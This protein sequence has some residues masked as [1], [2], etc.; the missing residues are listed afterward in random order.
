[1]IFEL[2]KATTGDWDSF[3]LR[4]IGMAAQRQ[5]A[6][7]FGGDPVRMRAEAVVRVSRILGNRAASFKDPSLT[8]LTDFAVT[9]SL[10]GDLNQWTTSERQLLTEI[11]KAK[12]GQA[13]SRYLKLMQ[14][15]ERLRLAMIRL[16]S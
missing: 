13:E 14:R 7:K 3:Q 12:A 2:E 8:P 16:G 9:L 4:K 5:M 11:I 10:V 1:M 15:H 6:E